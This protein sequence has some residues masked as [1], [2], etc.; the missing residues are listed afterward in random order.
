M[1]VKA[2]LHCALFHSRFGCLCLEKNS[3]KL[4]NASPMLE[5]FLYYTMTCVGGKCELVAFFFSRFGTFEVT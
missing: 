2:L 1:S 5:F 4:P 3:R